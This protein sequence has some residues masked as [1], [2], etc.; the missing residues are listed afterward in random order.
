MV[1]VTLHFVWQRHRLLGQELEAAIILPLRHG[2]QVGLQFLTR[3]CPRYVLSYFCSSS[4]VR[5]VT[6]EQLTLRNVQIPD[7]KDEAQLDN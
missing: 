2:Q 7:S 6:V 4:S 1:C 3:R 5:Q